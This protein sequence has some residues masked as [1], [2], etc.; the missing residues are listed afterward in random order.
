MPICPKT[1]EAH[2]KNL[3]QTNAR[4][5]PR[6]ERTKRLCFNFSQPSALSFLSSPSSSSSSEL[7]PSR[8]SLPPLLGAN[9]GGRDVLPEPRDLLEEIPQRRRH[10]HVR[11]GEEP[12]RARR[13]V[14]AHR[15]RQSPGDEEGTPALANRGERA[16]PSSSESKSESR[17]SA[18][19]SPERLRLRRLNCSARRI[20]SST[21]IVPLSAF[22]TA[23]SNAG[24]WPARSFSAAA[25][26][27][28]WPS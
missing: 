4:R 1:T 18:P 24:R 17:A 8:D 5:E 14:V 26:I 21:G 23:S 19:P 11:Q 25:S 22:V 27:P 2:K 13:V 20:T 16:K 28:R 7:S 12:P 15:R 6:K 3:K 10:V 9:F